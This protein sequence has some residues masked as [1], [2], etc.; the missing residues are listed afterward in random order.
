MLN[1]KQMPQKSKQRTTIARFPDG[2]KRNKTFTMDKK[3]KKKKTNREKLLCLD[4]LDTLHYLPS[5]HIG[6][7]HGT[8]AWNLDQQ[9]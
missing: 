4:H 3:K 7:Q 1:L 6:T 9:L 5:Y 2:K 8:T